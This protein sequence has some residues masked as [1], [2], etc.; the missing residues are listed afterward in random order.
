V[1][2]QGRRLPNGIVRPWIVDW[3]LGRAELERLRAEGLDTDL[4]PGQVHALGVAIADQ[5]GHGHAPAPDLAPS[6]ELMDMIEA[7]ATARDAPVTAGDQAQ[8]QGRV[9]VHSQRLSPANRQ[10]RADRNGLTTPNGVGQVDHQR[11]EQRRS[12]QGKHRSPLRDHPGE[13]WS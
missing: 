7:I 2:A 1:T 4:D 9:Q 8:V 10:A 5:A 12:Q 13:E 6:P 11:R 3:D